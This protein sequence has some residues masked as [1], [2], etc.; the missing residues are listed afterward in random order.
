MNSRQFALETRIARDDIPAG[1][2]SMTLACS[3]AD[4]QALAGRL[5][6]PSVNALTVTVALTA[7]KSPGSVHITGEVKASLTRVCV[8]SMEEMPEEIDAPFTLDLVTADV[9]DMLDAEEAY[10]DPAVADYDV[11]DDEG[12]VPVGEIAAQTVAL[13]MDPYPRKNGMPDVSTHG[14]AINAPPLQKKNP[15]SVLQGLKSPDGKPS[16]KAD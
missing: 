8:A 9:A 14:V 2:L 12:I 7:G 6:I 15:F 16:G 1:G 11:I 10:A 5:D 3:P 4:L 13:L